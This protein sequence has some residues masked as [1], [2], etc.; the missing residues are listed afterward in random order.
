M[1]SFKRARLIQGLT[2]AELAEVLGVST[3]TVG[4][5]ELGRGLPKAKR[6]QQVA[7]ALHTTVPDLLSEARERRPKDGAAS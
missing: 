5:W 7:D 3:V 6:L 1:N 4:K 2:Q